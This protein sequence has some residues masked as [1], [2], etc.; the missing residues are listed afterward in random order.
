MHYSNLMLPLLVCYSAFLLCSMQSSPNQCAASL[1]TI[2]L[3]IAYS[4]FGE[5]EISSCVS[6]YCFW[7]WQNYLELG[8]VKPSCSLSKSQLLDIAAV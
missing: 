2:E 1:Q 4:C 6:N 7:S 5:T 8:R 3:L